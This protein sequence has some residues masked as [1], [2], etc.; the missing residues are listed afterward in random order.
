[1]KKTVQMLIVLASAAA[2]T[3]ISGCSAIG[4]APTLPSE[5]IPDTISASSEAAKAASEE[6]TGSN[7]GS[8]LNDILARRYIE[9]AM[10]PYFAPNE[11]I[12]PSRQGEEQYVGADVEL[13]RYIADKLGVECRI[14]PLEFSAVLTGVTEGKYDLAISALAYTPARAE[15]MEMSKGYRFDEDNANNFGLMI[16]SGDLDTIKS[17]DDLTDKIVVCQSGSL[18]E[19]FATEQI[20]ACRELKRVSAT[21]DGFLMVQEGK[22]DAVVTEKKTAE[23]FIAANAESSMVI[24]PDFSFVVNESTSGTRIGIPKG[25]TALLN[26]INEIIDEVT[27]SGIYDEWYEKYTAYAKTLGL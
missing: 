19:L 21:T 11:F 3:A 8:R 27:A 13:A 18:Q 2:L 6:T 24:V 7:G 12:D 10:E 9:I 5:T 16:R 14:V 15:A 20:P 17:A 4:S 1:M 25:E 23:L 26:R 22:A